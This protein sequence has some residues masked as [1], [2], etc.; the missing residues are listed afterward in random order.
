M[1]TSLKGVKMSQLSRLIEISLEPEWK[2]PEEEN[3]L[4]LNQEYWFETVTN[5]STKMIYKLIEISPTHYTVESKSKMINPLREL[6][7]SEW[8]IILS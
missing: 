3:N 2:I 5:P 8:R 7:R 4:K 6:C 1:I